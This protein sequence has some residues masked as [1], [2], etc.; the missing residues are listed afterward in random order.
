[1]VTKL[2]KHNVQISDKGS[3]DPIQSI[4]NSQNEFQEIKNKITKIK[5]DII[6]LKSNE[7]EELKKKLREFDKKVAE[8]R[9]EFL[10]N[11]PFSYNEKL[12]TDEISDSYKKIM[13]YKSKLVDLEQEAADFNKQEKLFDM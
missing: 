10:V 5:Q 2:K 11:L 9:K 3:E 6:Q 13:E 8:F 12:T 4:D 1:M 7:A